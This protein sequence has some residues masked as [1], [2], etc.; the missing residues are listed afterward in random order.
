MKKRIINIVAFLLLLPFIAM[1]QSMTVND[2]SLA[3][4]YSFIRP[5]YNKLS[6]TAALDPFYK[7]LS[8]LKA[9]NTGTVSIVH[10]GDSHIQADL[11]SGTVRSGLQ[12]F[13][14]NAGRGLVFPYQL[15]RS[16][17]PQ[18]INSS[19]NTTWQFNRIA[20]PEISIPFGISGYGITTNAEN[21]NITLSLKEEG[22]VAFNQ[23]KFFLEND[24]ATWM[25]KTE[26]NDNSYFLKKENEDSSIYHEVL[27]D[28]SSMSFSL[29]SSS[30]HT[31]EFYG[32][33]LENEN[34]GIVYH[35]IGVNGARYDQYN[36]ASLFWKQLPALKADLYIISLGT[37][38]A[39][40]VSFSEAAFIKELNIFID[41]LKQTSPDA[42]IIITTAPDSYKSRRYYNTVL[43]GINTAI[44]N[45]SNKNNIPVWDLYKIGGGYRSAYNWSRR[46]LMN[47]DKIH[48]TADGYRLQGKL[49]LV[50]L[51][52]SYNSYTS[53][54]QGN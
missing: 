43:R 38:E 31:K 46:G 48:F 16:N 8:L 1:P 37:N 34:P 6:S 4:R 50:A 49:L 21:V 44:T 19:S 24:T 18:D 39:Q 7:K 5:V 13:F 28:K 26:N 41:K 54:Y 9:T 23:L 45:F 30:G 20:H 25:I 52:K 36:I 2:N 3:A 22:N 35:T 47:R 11:L 33:S 17:A 10:I 15:A 12:E 53:T 42:A 40:A 29:S 27:L 14:G 32:V 51:A